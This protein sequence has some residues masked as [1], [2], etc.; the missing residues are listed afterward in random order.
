MIP[1]SR[2]KGRGAYRDLMLNY[3]NEEEDVINIIPGRR[4]IVRSTLADFTLLNLG[5]FN[6]I[7]VRKRIVMEQGFTFTMEASITAGDKNS[8]RALYWS[9]DKANYDADINLGDNNNIDV[10]LYE[11]DNISIG[12]G[13]HV[14]GRL[15][16]ANSGTTIGDNNILIDFTPE[17]T[18]GSTVYG[19]PQLSELMFETEIISTSTTNDTQIEV[20]DTSKI[21]LGG[22]IFFGTL[23]AAFADRTVSWVNGNFVGFDVPLTYKETT[24]SGSRV[25]NHYPET[26]E[27]LSSTLSE[28]VDEGSKRIMISDLGSLHLRDMTIDGTFN[29]KSF[30][31]RSSDNMVIIRDATDK[32]YPAGTTVISDGTYPYSTWDTSC[33]LDSGS[34]YTVV[35]A[36]SSAYIGRVVNV[37]GTD[38][39]IIGFTNSTITLNLPV[40]GGTTDLSFL[41][42]DEAPGGGP[43][44]TVLS[45]SAAGNSLDISVVDSSTFFIG[46]TIRISEMI[47]VF[48]VVSIIGDTITLNDKI[49]GDSVN[50]SFYVGV[51]ELSI[52]VDS[53]KASIEAGALDLNNYIFGGP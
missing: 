32:A 25:F 50:D 28:D 8:V 23:G 9:P 10:V 17:I 35:G 43:S 33:S 41:M 2:S 1:S 29:T 3:I 20:D 47:K 34:T 52:D 39:N 37:S 21:M 5:L 48:I 46:Q 27:V 53:T 38:Y 51:V 12:S 14:R 40:P 18:E 19:L 44:N 22:K 45:V 16:V 7:E 4:N 13:N 24:I 15:N 11:K 42:V 26:E 31:Q 49:F 6:H 36:K 30:F